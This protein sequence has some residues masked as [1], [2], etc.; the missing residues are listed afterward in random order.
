M[1]E[2]LQWDDGYRAD[3]KLIMK[4]T[5]IMND[6][7]KLFVGCGVMMASVCAAENGLDAMSN[8]KASP[9]PL[10]G[11]NY[12]VTNRISHS[13]AKLVE[14]DRKKRTEGA[15]DLFVSSLLA[16]KAMNDKKIGDDIVRA[17]KQES[18]G[19]IKLALLAT[20]DQLGH[21]ALQGLL[22]EAAKDKDPEIRNMVTIIKKKLYLEPMISTRKPSSS[23]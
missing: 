1:V 21:P 9:D 7:I 11:V 19:E 8:K 13:V 4:K 6:G 17:Y 20:L 2:L 14:P 18:L 23:N 10:K 16:K 15:S 22:D 5:W 12:G 3:A